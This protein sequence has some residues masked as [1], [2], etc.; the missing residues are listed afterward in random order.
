ML[1][2]YQLS[3]TS[4]IVRV[5]I[6]QSTTGSSPGQGFTGLGSTSTGLKIGTI[7]DVESGSTAY[8]SAG[9]TIQTIATL[10]TYA[11]PSAGD[12]RFKEV[13]STNHPGIYEL[14]FANA[15]FAV[16]TAKSLLISITGVT[17]MADCD[18]VIPLRS[19]N[20]YDGVRGGLMALPNANA[21]AAS[22]LPTLDGS[23]HLLVYSVNQGVTVATNNDKA[24]YSLSQTFPA[25]FASLSIDGSGRITV[26]PAGLDP[27]SIETGITAS[28][29]LTN[30]AGTQLT[31]I[32]LRQALALILAVD[33]ALVSG[34]TSGSSTITYGQTAVASGEDRVVGNVDVYGNRTS[35]TLKVP[36]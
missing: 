9:S 18:V 2:D 14:Q 10:G 33:A 5:K 26:A 32:N 35:L 16:A 22:G 4:I 7:A 36:S 8:T 20:P 1:I 28:S 12:C 21:G 17:N 19:V 23:S 34:A 29:A 6:R 31:A 13:D 24:G 30:D 25:N 15:R 11:A 27:V 3:Q